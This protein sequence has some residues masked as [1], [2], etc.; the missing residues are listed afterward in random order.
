MGR[1]I[2]QMETAQSA[3]DSQE[4]VR[5]TQPDTDRLDAYRYRASPEAVSRTGYE[6]VDRVQFRRHAEQQLN[7]VVTSLESGRDQMKQV[8]ALARTGY[9]P[10]TK[11][12]DETFSQAKQAYS[13]AIQD[14]V[15]LLWTK[16]T[17]GRM[18][19]SQFYKATEVE[20]A[21]LQQEMSAARGRNPQEHGRLAREEAMLA[22]VLRASGYAHANFGLALIRSSVYLPR[23]ARDQQM[24]QGNE[25]LQM[26]ATCDPWMKGDPPRRPADPNFKKHYD[27]IMRAVNA[28]PY[29]DGP[30]APIDGPVAPIDG[31]VAQTPPTTDV[32]PGEAGVTN[33]PFH[34]PQRPEQTVEVP[35]AAPPQAGTAEIQR[36][37]TQLSSQERDHKYALE[38]ARADPRSPLNRYAHDVARIQN[39]QKALA[40]QIVQ[41]GKNGTPEQQQA[42][43]RMWGSIQTVPQLQ[44][45]LRSPDAEMKPTADTVRSHPNFA[46]INSQFAQFL[47]KKVQLGALDEWLK[48]SPQTKMFYDRMQAMQATRRQLANLEHAQATQNSPRPEVSPKSDSSQDPA[49]KIET[50]PGEIETPPGTRV[51]TPRPAEPQV[52]IPADLSAKVSG[53]AQIERLVKDAPAAFAEAQQDVESGNQRRGNP[54]NVRAFFA[55]AD[56]LL[57]THPPEKI[58]EMV[59]AQRTIHQMRLDAM[60]PKAEQQPIKDR[61]SALQTN[62]DQSMAA[63][64]PESKTAL[65]AAESDLMQGKEQLRSKYLQANPEYQRELQGIA[66]VTLPNSAQRTQMINQ[67][68]SRYLPKVEKDAQYQAEVKTL[69]TQHRARLQATDAGVANYALARK[70]L[71]DCLAGDRKAFLMDAFMKANEDLEAVSHAAAIVQSYE[72]RALLLSG[73]TRDHARAAELMTAAQ[74]DPGAAQ[75]L[76]LPKNDALAAHKA[77]LGIDLTD[78]ASQ[79]LTV[80]GA[81]VPATGGMARGLAQVTDGTVFGGRL[82]NKSAA[83]LQLAESFALDPRTRAQVDAIAA[84]G[85]TQA[86]GLRRDAGSLAAYGVTYWGL[87]LL[88]HAGK[89]LPGPAKV[90]VAALAA[91]GTSDYLE[92]YKLDGPINNP[93][94]WARG[95]G[96]GLGGHGVYNALL[97]KWSHAAVAQATQTRVA[98]VGGEAALAT[99]GTLKVQAQTMLKETGRAL[100]TP[101]NFLGKNP[102]VTE[103]RIAAADAAQLLA[104]RRNLGAMQYYRAVQTAFAVGAGHETLKIVDGDTKVDGVTDA[105]GKVLTSGAY[106]AGTSAIIAPAL[107]AP[108]R[109]GLSKVPGGASSWI[110]GSEATAAYAFART[111]GSNLYRSGMDYTRSHDLQSA[112]DATRDSES[113]VKAFQRVYPTIS[114]YEAR[115]RAAIYLQLI[116]GQEQVQN[117]GR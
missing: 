82:E 96:V 56:G 75:F 17:Q 117:A 24:G 54:D 45:F 6:H 72:A 12:Y 84:N 35:V 28:T 68:N 57:R 78:Q 64:S 2:R 108:L 37:R 81:P 41:L 27:P 8:H 111:Y 104:I 44:Q 61:L 105:T 85:N 67:V 114:D 92:D 38:A 74:R 20:R 116:R 3:A 21:R 91:A 73:N 60:V 110:A 33:P 76:A 86:I 32:R 55:L 7:T 53:L 40:D 88:K 31:P 109:F 79:P 34:P 77:K 30:A 16:D 103:A 69:D 43:A 102:L 115:A 22:D 99:P 5:E 93:G 10:G 4:E 87:G 97:G 9:G 39:E 107:S 23:A 52:E 98:A 113:L 36:L 50:P 1:Q 112:A 48:Q 70:A 46:Q 106:A 19:P 95:A 58:S 59:E 42:L 94:A 51:E 62:I 49:G 89:A 47:N 29:I 100:A 65:V 63:L 80:F 13:Q 101:S 15:Q 26:A 71:D 66:N 90:V 11:Q 25:M 18:V 14:A 83:T